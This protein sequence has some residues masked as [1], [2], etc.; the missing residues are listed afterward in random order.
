MRIAYLILT[1][2]KYENT[3]VEWQKK[4]MLKD[5]DP[6]D[7]Y[8]LGHTMKPEKR[9][10]SWGAPDDYR[11]LPYKFHDCFKYVNLEGY[12]WYVL[13]DDDTYVYHHRLVE[14]LSLYRDEKYICIGKQLEH[15]QH[16]KWGS[17]MSGGAGT[18]LSGALYW[19]ICRHIRNHKPGELVKH[20]CADI[21]LSMW[22]RA[23]PGSH[24]VDCSL[25]H[26][27]IYR[28]KKDRLED[29][30]TFHHLKEWKD[31]EK[32]ESYDKKIDQT[33]TP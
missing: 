12:H 27:D 15:V 8:Y 2:E 30:I 11:N 26:P 14:L 24:F 32:Y 7:M 1:C 25:F 10:F 5:V 33:V 13:I 29:A 4:T 21:C 16:T 31:F 23:I 3:R 9:I 18:I 6:S 17:Y 28:P 20:W 19:E 22:V